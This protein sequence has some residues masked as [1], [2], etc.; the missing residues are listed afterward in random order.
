MDFLSSRQ[1]VNCDSSGAPDFS[2]ILECD[3]ID[4]VCDFNVRIRPCTMA[5]TPTCPLPPFLT[6]ATTTAPITM[7][8]T[9]V[10]TTS[11]S[12][13]VEATT[14]NPNKMCENKPAGSR[15]LHGKGCKEYIYCY[16]NNGIKGAV[17]ACQANTLFNPIVQ[18][19]VTGYDALCTT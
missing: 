14:I 11:A 5:P 19:C 4:E 6:P 12:T 3:F 17:Y 2:K 8:T 13:T 15:H 1:Y 7:A 16:T 18:Q 9:T 10:P